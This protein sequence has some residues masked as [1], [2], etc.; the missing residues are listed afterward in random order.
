MP[1]LTYPDLVNEI[2]A[3][4]LTTLKSISEAELA[5]LRQDANRI[6]VAGKGRS[7]LFMRAFAMRLM[8]LGLTV[9]VVDDVTT[10]A[11]GAGDL[12]VIG[13]GSGSTASLA[14]YANRAKSLQAR[15]ALITA[16]ESS[17]I[18][19]QAD[20][21]MFI[22]APSPKRERA[23]TS[24]QPMANLFEQTLLLVLDV[25]IIQLMSDLNLTA[26]QMFARHANLE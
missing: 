6:F 18:G 9:Y 21:I 4:L 11:I 16:A 26:E 10:P 13:S 24:I 1:L 12:L 2:C 20:Y 17:P 7:G 15:L 3:E 19:A 14:Q 23:G 8:H 22:P 25:L 5:G